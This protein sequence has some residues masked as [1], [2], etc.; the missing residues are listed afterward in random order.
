MPVNRCNTTT[1]EVVNA[2]AV[3]ATEASK[4]VEN[5]TF[6]CRE[7]FKFS[8]MSSVKTINCTENGW[9]NTSL[10]CEEHCNMTDVANAQ[11]V[12]GTTRFG[13]TVQLAC[14]T[15]YKLANGSRIFNG[16]CLSNGQWS[17][18]KMH[19]CLITRC[20]VLPIQPN[21]YLSSTSITYNTS[22][23]FTCKYGYALPDTTTTRQIRCT[24]LEKWTATLPECKPV[25]CPEVDKEDSWTRNTTSR[26]YNTYVKYTCNPGMRMR[27]GATHRVMK[28]DANATWSDNV[29]DCTN[30]RCPP[31]IFVVNT[32]SDDMDAEN[33]T[34]A[35]VYC[36]Q[37]HRFMPGYSPSK[38]ITCQA[39]L[40]WSPIL[41]G[42]QPV[43]CP[44]VPAAGEN[45]AADTASTLLDTVVNYQCDVG[46]YY[47]D[48]SSRFH[49]RCEYNGTNVEWN[50]TTINNCL[51][52]ECPA[53]PGI[54]NGTQETNLDKYVYPKPVSY[55]CF[56]GYLFVDG[57]NSRVI[58]CNEFG[59]WNSTDVLCNK[60]RCTPVP[61]VPH[62]VTDTTTSI[63][64]TNVT[65]TCARGHEWPPPKT[66]HHVMCEQRGNW[67]E[68]AESIPPCKPKE[69][70]LVTPQIHSEVNAT[71]R[72]Y[73]TFVLH[74]CHAGY[75]FANDESETLHWCNADGVWE[76]AVFLPCYVVHCP[77][78]PD[79]Q[80][81]TV[82]TNDT[83]YDTVVNVT[84]MPGYQFP[85][86]TKEKVV[87]C[88]ENE[89]WSGIPQD[90][91]GKFLSPR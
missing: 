38:E 42:C 62:T 18:D 23:T 51:P 78:M 33:G 71:T 89:T 26:T 3:K 5:I 20:P 77:Q 11:P 55:K 56:V 53:P 70:V 4:P 69:C 14:N 2:T 43:D 10:V 91:E 47:T 9:E 67:N 86:K 54:T 90:C 66:S 76:P 46:H 22:V 57:L 15:G 31:L 37:G 58:A 24:E 17:V 68:T 32:T 45:S 49:I 59:Q 81:A 74:S 36:I 44:E 39:N 28:C 40:K 1:L 7:G 60:D 75:R 85:D 16:K 41:D 79:I 12:D 34:S 63:W 64:Y 88:L 8:D 25:L 21:Q 65:Y 73:D 48:N 13:N 29:T 80:N 82:N 30:T 61:A 87:Q 27:D 50:T 83:E 72:V 52:I 35:T 19:E 84:C 6:V